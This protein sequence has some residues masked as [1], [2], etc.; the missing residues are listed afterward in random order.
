MSKLPAAKQIVGT[1]GLLMLR[2]YLLGRDTGHYDGMIR[3]LEANG[4]RV[5]PAFANGLD[6]RPAIEAFFV[7][8]GE[9]QVDAILNLTGFSLVGG[10]A[11]NDVDAAVE[12][13]TGL[14]VPYIAAHPIE[15]QSLEQWGAGKM[16]LL[17]LET[18][19]MLAIPELDGAVAP[20]VFGGRSATANSPPMTMSG[21]CTAV[22]SA[23]MR[24][25]AR[26]SA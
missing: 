5:I 26:S 21:R 10:P 18:T 13:L 16:G 8:E 11:Y 19:M 9:P 14:D 15:F 23:P 7:R 22:P 3:T 6:A 20:S 24:W 4:L 2:S 12:T 25:P 1:V 17:P